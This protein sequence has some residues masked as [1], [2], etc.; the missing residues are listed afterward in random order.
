[1]KKIL[2]VSVPIALF[3]V[4][5]LLIVSFFRIA[6]Q[7]STDTNSQ[8][9]SPKSA[10]DVA[11]SRGLSQIQNGNTEEGIKE[12]EDA[13][14]KFIN[15]KNQAKLEYV[16]QQLDYVKSTPKPITD[17][18]SSTTKSVEQPIQKIEQ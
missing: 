11:L 7:Q 12:L 13:R 4:I 8:K 3:L 6:P 17:E 2:I 9:V 18:G 10:G 1:M 5:G 15:E 14:L 16:D